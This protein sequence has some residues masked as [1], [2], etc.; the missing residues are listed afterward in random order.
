[1]S[2][3]ADPAVR[4]DARYTYGD[5]KSWDDDERW[6][7]IDGEA[8]RMS[9]PNLGHQLLISQFV[10]RMMEHLGGPAQLARCLV[11]P[12]PFD[13]LVLDHP[14][15]DVDEA[16]TV[17]QPDVSVLCDR[18]KLRSFGCVGGPDIVVEIISP[19]SAKRDLAE[20]HA[21][22]ERAGVREYWVVDPGNRFVHVFRL[23]DDG[24]FGKPDI[25]TEGKA[26]VS[27]VLP[28]FTLPAAEL[29]A[30]LV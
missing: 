15:Q 1:M 2:K 11:V 8:W 12:A 26:I 14:G 29:F 17:V 18:S 25:V 21:L 20:K 10:Y 5:Y 22:Y 3:M 9:A 19:Y 24:K 6:E 13:V 28:G 23:G 30:A 7:L 16:R 4:P 27:S